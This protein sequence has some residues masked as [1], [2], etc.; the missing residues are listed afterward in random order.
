MRCNKWY[1]ETCTGIKFLVHKDKK[2][3][4]QATMQQRLNNLETKEVIRLRHNA[5]IWR[6][7]NTKG[8]EVPCIEMEALWLD[9]PKYL[10]SNKSVC[11]TFI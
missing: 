9:D 5:D 2:K 4:K 7:S 1:F 10:H 11:Q 3:I 6:Q 8:S